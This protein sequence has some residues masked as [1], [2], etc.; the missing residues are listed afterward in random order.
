MP[1]LGALQHRAMPIRI[2]V[3]LSVVTL[4]LVVLL[5]SPQNVFELGKIIKYNLI[6]ASISSMIISQ[7]K[8]AGLFIWK[9]IAISESNMHK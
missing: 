5:Q 3:L 8:S 2:C 4:R 1:H 6:I 7:I 9:R